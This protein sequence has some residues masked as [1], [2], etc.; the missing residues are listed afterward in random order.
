M[1]AD[2]HNAILSTRA[3]A[4]LLNLPLSITVDQARV[5]LG[6]ISR[7]MF[8]KLIHDGEVLT[9]KIGTRTAVITWSII[10]YLERN[11]G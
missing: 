11:D 7:G 8:Y 9:K 5:H 1:T 4:K 10:A 3:H 6:G 2:T